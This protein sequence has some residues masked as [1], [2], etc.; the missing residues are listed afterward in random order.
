MGLSSQRRSAD[1]S[2]SSAGFPLAEREAIVSRPF[3]VSPEIRVPPDGRTVS[4]LVPVAVAAP[5]SYAV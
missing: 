4:V 5:Y 1:A 3:I 2:R